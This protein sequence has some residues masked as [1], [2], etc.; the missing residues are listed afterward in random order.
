MEGFL[1]KGNFYLFFDFLDFFIGLEE[2]AQCASS[3]KIILI[4]GIKLLTI[5]FSLL[6]Y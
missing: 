5:V 6:R 2:K 1:V 3:P 4:T